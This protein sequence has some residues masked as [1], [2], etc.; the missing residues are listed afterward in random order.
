MTKDY[1][2]V[3][4]VSIM[5]NIHPKTIQR[6]IREGKLRAAK[7]GKGWRITG[8]DLSTFIENDSN[9]KP[10]SG[11]RQERNIIAS[12][13]VD[14][15]TDGKEDAIRIM[16]TLTASLNAKPSEYGRS[17]MQSQ[18]IER[19]NMIRITLWGSIRFMAIMMDTIAVL[20]EQYKEE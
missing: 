16:N 15:I 18:Y 8:H 20:T 5:L 2:T 3:D 7:V 19:E 12:S 17:S 13:V 6:Y 11:N 9:E 1:Y 14:I 4:Q 10:A